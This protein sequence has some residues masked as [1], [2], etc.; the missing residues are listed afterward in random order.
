MG[1]KKIKP[2]THTEHVI[3]KCQNIWDKEKIPNASGEKEKQKQATQ[4]QDSRQHWIQQYQ[5]PK[6]NGARFSKLTKNGFQSRVLYLATILTKMQDTGVSETR[7]YASFSGRC[8][9]KP[10]SK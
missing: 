9:T 4:S 6:D 10:E 2:K 5:K 8:C 7:S 3:I 1:F